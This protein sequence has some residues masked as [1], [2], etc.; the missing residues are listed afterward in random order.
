MARVRRTRADRE[1]LAAAEVAEHVPAIERGDRLAPVHVAAGHR[2]STVGRLRVLVQRQLLA[3]RVAAGGWDVAVP[4]LHHAPAPV[5]RLAGPG[6]GVDRAVDL[7]VAALA[8]VADPQVAVG[9]VEGEPPRVSQAALPDLVEPGP[10][11]VRVGRG[12]AVRASST[13]SR[14]RRSGASCR[15][16]VD[17]S[18]GAVA[19]VAAA[20]AVAH[21][22]VQVAVRARTRAS[23]R[24]GSRTAGRS[25]MIVRPEPALD[26]VGV[27]RRGPVLADHGVA[28]RVREV[29]EEPAVGRELRVEREAQEALL[30]ALGHGGA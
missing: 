16:R 22:D 23:R 12:D 17:W 7:L 29:H 5:E 30:A 13:S 3:A 21:A 14:S 6:A 27:R 11:D 20:A 15:A 24:C 25:R 10:A 19:R 8:D 1:D 26:A 4:A 9:A 18:L 28:V 2:A